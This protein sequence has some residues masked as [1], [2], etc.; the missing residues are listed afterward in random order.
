MTP[1]TTPTT[2]TLTVSKYTSGDG[3]CRELIA[4]IQAER[5]SVG[6]TH[7]II[8]VQALPYMAQ[9]PCDPWSEHAKGYFGRL[10]AVAATW[11]ITVV[12]E[13]S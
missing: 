4:L 3:L 11:G 13:A 10:V 7:P 9:R 2:H 1:T 6:G 5:V 12:K 8:L